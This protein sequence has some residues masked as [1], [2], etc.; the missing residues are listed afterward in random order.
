MPFGDNK[1]KRLGDIET[2]DL[3]STLKWCRE[4]GK[5]D[6]GDAISNVLTERALGAHV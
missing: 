1:G 6:L 3:E 4:K 2:A 5:A